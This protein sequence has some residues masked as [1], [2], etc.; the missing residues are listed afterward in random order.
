[1]IYVI[2]FLIWWLVGMMI[3]AY[4]DEK[5]YHDKLLQW[6]EQFP[7]GSPPL[8]VFVV[9][10]FFPVVIYLHWTKGNTNE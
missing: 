5:Y 2:G 6:A 1:M 10:M 8:G 3:N 7:F 4:L 9:I